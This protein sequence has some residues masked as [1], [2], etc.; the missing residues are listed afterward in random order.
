VVDSRSGDGDQQENGDDVE[1]MGIPVLEHRRTLQ[2]PPAG[3]DVRALLNR[4]GAPY[5]FSV[6]DALD[7]Y[8]A[9]QMETLSEF[10]LQPKRDPTGGSAIPRLIER[11]RGELERFGPIARVE[12]DEN[13]SKSRGGNHGDEER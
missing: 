9:A 1:R 8:A 7:G 6:D 13:K 2:W 4:I 11:N 10:S 12:R 5:G 3:D